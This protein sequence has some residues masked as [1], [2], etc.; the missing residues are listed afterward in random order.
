MN[1]PVCSTTDLSDDTTMCPHCQSD[2][3]TFQLIVKANQQRQTHRKLISALSL[4]AAV[5]AIGW[6][7]VGIF[8]GKTETGTPEISPEVKLQGE[9]RTPADS[10]LIA[11]LTTENASLKSENSL[12]T[13]KLNTPVAKPTEKVVKIEKA[14]KAAKTE[15]TSSSKAS[16]ASEGGTTIHTVRNGD[17]FWIISRKYFGSGT[18]YKQIAKDN[19]LTVKTKLHK[20]QKIK[21]QK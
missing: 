9:V 11:M 10:E 3:E 16:V 21:I 19:G 13:L 5:T 18:H 1:C 12:L 4:F 6:A 20:G 15:K 7:S 17:T 2:L 8:S 14:M